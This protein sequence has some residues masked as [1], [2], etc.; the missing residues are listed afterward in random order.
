MLM[1][2]SDVVVSCSVSQHQGLFTTIR[3]GFM[4]L[5]ILAKEKALMKKE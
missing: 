3:N 5:F 2:V 4:C 1:P